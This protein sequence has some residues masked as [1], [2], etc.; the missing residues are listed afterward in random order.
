MS[1]VNRACHGYVQ[2]LYCATSKGSVTIL[3]YTGHGGAVTIPNSING[4]PVTGI[5]LNAFYSCST[6]T[7]ITIPHSVVSIGEGAFY[8]CINLDTITVDQGNPRYQSVDGV[9]FNKRLTTLIQC[10]GA[11]SGHYVIP[12]RVTSIGRG[13]FYCC[14]NLTHITIPSRVTRIGKYAFFYCD[15]LVEVSLPESVVK[16]G[17]RAFQ[18]C[19]NLASITMSVGIT[20]IEDYTFA[21]CGKLL[22]VVIPDSVA[23]IGKYAFYTC[24]SLVRISLGK[25]LASFGAKA[26]EYCSN[27]LVIVVHSGNSAYS[28]HNG[29]LFDKNKTTL[30]Q[31]PAGKAGHYSI[32]N[33]VTTIASRAF[34]D[35]KGLTHIK[36]PFSVTLIGMI[37]ASIECVGDQAFCYCGGLMEINVD[38]KNPSY[39][40][41][42]GVLFDKNRATLIQCPPGKTGSYSVPHGVKNIRERA[43]ECCA[44]LTGVTLPIS[45]ESIRSQ[46]F[47]C[48]SGLTGLYFNGDAPQIFRSGFP[49]Q[50]SLYRLAG[51]TG[52]EQPRYHSFV[53]KLWEDAPVL[54]KKVKKSHTKRQKMCLEQ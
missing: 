48:C 50:C 22:A 13:A 38:K 31:F 28:S 36:I 46:A 42:D 54:N 12:D 34:Y 5:G 18:N 29:V 43:F 6:L 14:Y 49:R 52:W 33:G 37:S 7:S 47:I 40:S 9:L 41:V 8:G 16:I 11:K 10:P 35:C 1:R 30:F 53:L 45:I 32:P 39:S 17:A 25:T 23:K 15:S 20:V 4:R 27:L 19:G 24:T 3:G 21:G 51:A 2:G 44:G 26:F